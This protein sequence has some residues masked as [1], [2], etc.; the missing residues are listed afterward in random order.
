MEEDMAYSKERITRLYVDGELNT[1]LEIC[2]HPDH[3]ETAIMLHTPTDEAQKWY[4]KFDLLLDAEEARQLGKALIEFADQ[5][6][7]DRA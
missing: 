6:D 1:C 3:P 5:F 2:P 4:G 7:E